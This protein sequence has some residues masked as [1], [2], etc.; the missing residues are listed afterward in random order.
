MITNNNGNMAVSL[1]G[2][3]EGSQISGWNCLYPTTMK[4]R[5]RLEHTAIHASNYNSVYFRHVHSKID[6]IDKDGSY[7]RWW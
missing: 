3:K 1:Q 6:N 2:L 5:G 4:G 7:L